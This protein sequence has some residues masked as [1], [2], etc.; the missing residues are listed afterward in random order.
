MI[1]DKSCLL[2]NSGKKLF[3]KDFQDQI[4][5]KIKAQK[6]SKEFLF[7]VFEGYADSNHF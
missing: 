6:Q 3:G 7:N 5:D 2:E 1:K 4:T